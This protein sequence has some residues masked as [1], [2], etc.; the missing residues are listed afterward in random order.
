MVR[1]LGY[2]ARGFM[3]LCLLAFVTVAQ[4]AADETMRV[5]VD[6]DRVAIQGYDTVAYFTD[7]GPAKGLAEFAHD[8]QGAKWLFA[9]AE[10]RDLFAADPEK[11]APRFGGFCAMGSSMGVQ[12]SVDPQA[13]TIV[14]DKLYLTHSPAALV[15]FKTDTLS[16]IAK[17]EIFW[18]TSVLDNN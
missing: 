8:W 4:S 9:T 6:S 16:H 12:A 2:M 14:D 13:W 10:H 1:T 17:A 5:N 15:K 18:E 3:A 11:Y 7:G